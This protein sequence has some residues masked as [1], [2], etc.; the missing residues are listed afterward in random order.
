MCDPD[1]TAPDTDGSTG[2]TTCIGTGG[3]GCAAKLACPTAGTGLQTIC[4]QIYDFETNQPFA[5]AG[6]VGTRCSPGATTGPCALVIHAY[7]AVA[8]AGSMGQAPALTTGEV[9]T[10]D[11]GRYQV[12]S[13]PISGLMAPFVALG[14][15]DADQPAKKGPGGVTNATGVVAPATAVLKDLDA[16]VVP[17]TTSDKWGGMPPL[18]TTH[19]VFAAVY[20]AHK[21]GRE[22]QAGVS[23]K[24]LT[25][26]ATTSTFYLG[27]TTRGSIDGAATATAANGTVLVGITGGA[28]TDQYSGQSTLPGGCSWDMHG[29]ASIPFAIVVQVF[30][31]TGAS[32][33]L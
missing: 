27:G 1:T 21:T 5:A 22:L 20:Q 24:T 17:K 29:A 25:G 13:I 32:C 2:V 3:G 23:F 8:F 30:R 11:C 4:G 18:D 6:A 15:D 7:D 9:Y 33:S 12:P 31:P 10:D 28:A 26:T 16:F 14:F 19:G